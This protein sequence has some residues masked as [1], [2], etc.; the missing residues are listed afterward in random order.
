MAPGGRTVVS[1]STLALKRGIHE[2]IGLD[3]L[4]TFPFGLLWRRRRVTISS[5]FVVT[6][7]RRGIRT[8][9]IDAPMAGSS[10]RS[11][12][13]GEGADLFNIREYTTQDDA[14]RIDW[15]ASAR[16][17]R[18]MLKEFERDQERTVE[19]LLD[20]RIAPGVDPDAFERLVETAASILDHCE[21]RGIRGRLLV[22]TGSGRTQALEGR[23]AMI[24]LAGVAARNDAPAPHA[25]PSPAGG[26]QRIVL[27][28]DPAERTS[29]HI[30]WAEPG[31]VA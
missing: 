4:S 10:S 13:P 12:R 24:H 19:I 26:S 31:K 23:G 7:R 11:P 29:L 30:E 17:E 14:R 9:R 25:L 22:S 2:T 16:L 6:P 3:L 5:R 18:M 20:E 28:T 1:S 27:S 21:H 15:K 8:L